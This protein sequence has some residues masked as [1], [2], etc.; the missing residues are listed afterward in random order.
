MSLVVAEPG[1]KALEAVHR[2][3]LSTASDMIRN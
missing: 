1:I 3:S 2:I